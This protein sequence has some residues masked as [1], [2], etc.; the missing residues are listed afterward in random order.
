MNANIGEKMIVNHLLQ[1]MRIILEK[2]LQVRVK[3]TNLVLNPTK[4]NKTLKNTQFGSSSL[5][6]TPWKET[7]KHS[8]GAEYS[9]SVEF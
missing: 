4:R 8:P 6:T 1:F 2:R 3:T 5:K 7:G 9:S